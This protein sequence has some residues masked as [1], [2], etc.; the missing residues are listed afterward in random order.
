MAKK[1]A[2]PNFR[3]RNETDLLT[4]AT[5]ALPADFPNP[6]RTGCPEAST[7]EAIARRRLSFPDIDDLADHIATCSPCFNAYRAHR[8][9]Y[10]TQYN[11][12]RY[13]AVLVVLAVLITASY[14]GRKI[15]P[16]TLRPP[17]SV[18]GVAP[19]TASLDFRNRTT[20]RSGQ[21]NPPNPQE[22][23]HLQRALLNVQIRLPLGTED[24]QYSLQFR[25][26]VGGIA[27]Q[28]TGTATWDGTTE[29]L[30]AQIDL[31]KME[32]G[33]YTLAVSKGVSSHRYSVFVD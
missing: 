28:T 18:S 22:T 24:G 13:A 11:R 20:E 21:A 33:Q 14:V 26:S 31:R 23:P 3:R 32:P 27:A 12:R 6:E 15:L 16:P 9:E 30:S 5:D 1:A 25:N 19:L 4:A 8:R 17:A 2:R 10:C 29:T 7:L